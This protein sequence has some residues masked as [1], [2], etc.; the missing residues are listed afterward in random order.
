MGVWNYIS[1][2]AVSLKRKASDLTS[3][4]KVNAGDV[5]SRH[6]PTE[7]TRSKILPFAV[8]VAKYSAQEALN[9]IPGGVSAYKVVKRALEDVNKS[10]DLPAEEKKSADR[11]VN[12]KSSHEKVDK[13]EEGEQRKLYEQMETMTRSRL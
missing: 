13:K 10:K 11:A 1:G 9:F 5:L 3:A 12:V 6:W 4:V 8:N 2:T 7:E